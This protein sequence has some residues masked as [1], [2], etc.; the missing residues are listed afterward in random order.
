[1]QEFFVNVSR[2]PR[3]LISLILGIFL[4][5]FGWLAPLL[6]NPVSAVALIGAVIGSLAFTY[7]TL[8]GMLGLT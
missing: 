4:A 5:F 6:K 2:Y 8:R 1:M 3:Y 7:F